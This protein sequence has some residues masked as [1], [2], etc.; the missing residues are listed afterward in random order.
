M[1]ETLLTPSSI[2]LYGRVLT[3]LTYQDDTTGSILGYNNF[4]Q[5]QLGPGSA[6]VVGTTVLAQAAVATDTVVGLFPGMF[7]QATFQNNPVFANNTTIATISAAGF[8]VANANQILQAAQNVLVTAVNNTGLN[9]PN[10]VKFARIYAFSFEGSIYSLPRPSIFVV[11]GGGKPLDITIGGQMGRTTLDQSGVIAREWEFSAPQ[12]Q[13]LR[14]WEYE[15]GDFS[16]RFDTEAGPFEQI[17]LAA[18]LRGGNVD[19][20]SGM[21]LSGMQLSGMQ[22]SGMQ[23]GVNPN[24]RNGR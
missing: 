14:Y 2:K 7:V 17:L 1:P 21:Q 16:I 11:H 12:S 24:S 8:S 20:R 9:N 23:L 4:L 5:S 22:L 19:V 10:A 13:D 3:D 18:A 6:S 15:K